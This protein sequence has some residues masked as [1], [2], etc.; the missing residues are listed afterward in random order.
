M[1]LQSNIL[2]G[3]MVRFSV[4]R[5]GRFSR[6]LCTFFKCFM[7]VCFAASFLLASCSSKTMKSETAVPFTF[8]Q[9]CDTQLGFTGYQR[10]IESFRQ[11]VRQIN[12]LNPDFVVICGDLVNKDDDKSFSDF[13][14]IK[15]NLKMPC[16]CVPGNHDVGNI[17]TSESIDR[18]RKI[19]GEDRFVVD[20]KGA[21]FVFVNT[22]IWKVVLQGESEKQD[23]WLKERL[24]GASEK[25]QQIFVVGHYPLFCR[26]ADEAE[27]YSNV[28][29]AKRVELLG[30]FE[31]Y[32]VDAVLHGHTHKLTLNNYKDMQ[33]V[34]G[35]TTSRNFDKRPLGFRVW[36]VDDKT[37]PKHKFV[38]LEVMSEIEK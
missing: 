1:G 36:Y 27:G 20:H 8:V 4:G 33:L 19:I 17:P 25:G 18:Y 28:P 2:F 30:L 29:L 34:G 23:A 14:Q 6:K 7:L 9:V 38:P 22:Q 35:E 31:Q 3:G 10:D 11:A 32:N 12:D 16:Y 13:K 26:N 21:A 24:K 5:F 15:K 37:P